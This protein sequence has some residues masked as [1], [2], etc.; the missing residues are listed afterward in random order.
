MS[1]KD[2]AWA[3]FIVQGDPRAL[4]N[5]LQGRC[6]ECGAVNP[7]DSGLCGGCEDEHA[8]SLDEHYDEEDD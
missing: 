7:L 3:R 2:K 8:R 4:A 5:E 6:I 1:A